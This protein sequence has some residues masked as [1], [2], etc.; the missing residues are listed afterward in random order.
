MVFIGAAETGD[1]VET[2]LPARLVPFFCKLS[3][4]FSG[5]EPGAPGG[6][7]HLATMTKMSIRCDRSRFKTRCW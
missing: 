3:K 5:T 6:S 1:R 4:I 7:R 2:G